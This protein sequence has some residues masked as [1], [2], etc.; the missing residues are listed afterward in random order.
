MTPEHRSGKE[1]PLLIT[2]LKVQ[3]YKRVR[4]VEITPGA[5]KHVILISGKNGNGK[6]STLDALTAAFGGAKAGAVDP[7]RHGEKEASIFVELDDGKLT[8]DRTFTPDGKTVLEVRDPDGTIRSPQA[9]LDKLIGHRCL[10]PLAFL[11]LAPKAQLAELMKVIP[12]AARIAELDAKRLKGFDRRTEIGRDLTKAEGE[13][14]RL[15]DVQVGKAIDVAALATEKARLAEQQRAGDGL[16]N[17]YKLAQRATSDAIAARDR[18]GQVTT[19]LERRISDLEIQLEAA[20]KELAGAQATP[21]G[22]AILEAQEAETAALAKLDESAAAWVAGQDVRDKIDADLARATDHNR[23]IAQAEASNARRTETAAAVE[24]L[25][26]D[27][28]LVTTGLATVDKRKADILAAAKLP[29]AGLA[30]GD[31]GIMLGGVPFAQASGAEQW[32]VA[33][34]I[35]IA[36]S[37]E[38]E[39]VW[40]KD[41]AHLDDDSLALVSSAAE[42]SGRRVWIERVGTR[43]PGA[44]IISDGQ[45][46]GGAA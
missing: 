43:D 25:K 23:A 26:A 17:T 36:A 13:L 10:D 41:G 2:C 30:I 15:V 28:D 8:I 32:R 40:I 34:A 20:R 14:A 22:A 19:V 38:L 6:S 18:N 7:V 12:D 16:G 44:I 46:V 5:D 27:R 4:N 9:M 42:A 21:F 45:V 35:A 37:P 33:L 11:Q 39:D 24:K 3:D 1:I 29:V 31:T